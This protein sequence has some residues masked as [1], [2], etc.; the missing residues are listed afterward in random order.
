MS[1]NEERLW[2]VVLCI[3]AQYRPRAERHLPH[4]GAYIHCR[5]SSGCVPCEICA[6]EIRNGLQM[7]RQEARA[8]SGDRLH[9]LRADRTRRDSYSILI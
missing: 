2:R 3:F 1:L 4:A 7:S 8:G 6:A 5:I 9:C